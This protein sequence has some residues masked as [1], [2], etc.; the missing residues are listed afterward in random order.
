MVIDNN[1]SVLRTSINMYCNAPSLGRRPTLGCAWPL[2]RVDPVERCSAARGYRSLASLIIDDYN[3]RKLRDPT[4]GERTGM[5]EVNNAPTNSHGNNLPL[6]S[7]KYSLF[8]C[9]STLHLFCISTQMYYR[10][11]NGHSSIAVLKLR[12]ASSHTRGMADALLTR[13]RAFSFT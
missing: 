9:P 3:H 5:A 1:N 8:D 12:C 10:L 6:R 11:Q 13:Y 4:P 2:L 7:R